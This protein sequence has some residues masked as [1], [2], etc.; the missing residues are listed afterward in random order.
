MTAL[1]VLCALVLGLQT[2]RVAGVSPSLIWNLCIVGLFAAL[3]GSRILL[4]VVNWTMVRSHPIWMLGL[5]MVHHPLLAGVAA[6]FAGAAGL[7][8]ARSKRMPLRATADVLAAPVALGLAFEQAGA[9]LAGSGF[10]TATSVPWAV[11]FTNP[12]AARWS[13]APL[14]V[15]VHPVQA[16]AAVVFLTIAVVLFVGMPRFSQHGDAAGAFLLTAGAAIYFTEFW[17]DPEGRGAILRGFL[18]GPQIGSIAMVLAGAWMLRRQDASRI[19]PNPHEV[20]A[21]PKEQA[22]EDRL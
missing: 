5:G 8:Y 7:F 21:P 9:L 12:L 1:G 20:E 14:G 10:G 13:G 11:V 3:V 2:A 17:R 6:A 22:S 4:I 18:D 16:Y 19:R 15:P